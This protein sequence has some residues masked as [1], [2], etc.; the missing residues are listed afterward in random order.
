MKNTIALLSLLLLLFSCSE[1]T[2]DGEA[3]SEI[4]SSNIEVLNAQKAAYTQQ[5]NDLSLKLEKVNE[6]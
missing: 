6:A 3:T 2:T 4:S 1:T 5:I